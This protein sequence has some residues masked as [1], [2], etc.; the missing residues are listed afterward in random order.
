M[1]GTTT[2]QTGIPLP[3]PPADAGGT[4]VIRVGIVDDHRLMLD[5]LTSWL[6][7]EAADISVEIAAS[8]WP[9]L[10]ADARFPVD[11]VLL[12]LDLGDGIPVGSKIVRLGTAGVAAVVVSTFADPRRVR[13]CLAA[14]ALGFVPKSED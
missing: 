6:G 9:D 4:R 14:G 10:L 2:P 13:E 8:A 1:T 3:R 5:A 7:A 12:D 11:V